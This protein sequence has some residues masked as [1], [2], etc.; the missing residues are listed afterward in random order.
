[1]SQN[2]EKVNGKMMPPTPVKI[3]T[4]PVKNASDQPRTI[5][6]LVMKKPSYQKT[7]VSNHLV[8]LIDIQIPKNGNVNLVTLLVLNVLV[9]KNPVVLIVTGLL[10]VDLY[11]TD[12]ASTHVQMLTIL[13]KVSVNLVTKL[14]ALVTEVID[15]LPVV[16]LLSYITENVYLIAQ[17]DGILIMKLMNVKDVT[18]VVNFVSDQ[19]KTI[20]KNVMLLR[21]DSVL[22]TCI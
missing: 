7:N 14:V 13:P 6:L 17:K 8:N 1:V 19:L 22:D 5:V 18:Q 4:I 9:E 21:P 10:L 2:V 12:I 3:V 15:V 11:I 20:V 16:E